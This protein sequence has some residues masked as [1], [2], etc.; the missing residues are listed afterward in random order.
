MQMLDGNGFKG[1]HLAFTSGF[2]DASVLVNDR[3]RSQQQDERNA[4]TSQNGLV[5]SSE[6]NIMVAAESRSAIM[7]KQALMSSPDVELRIKLCLKKILEETR[8]PG[9][10][11]AF[12]WWR[13]AITLNRFGHWISCFWRSAS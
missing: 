1:A 2:G 10:D 7:L 9:Q 8:W 11:F 13:G 4:I 3:I 5:K 12:C 6:E